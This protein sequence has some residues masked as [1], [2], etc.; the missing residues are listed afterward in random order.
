MYILHHTIS[1]TPS[2]SKQR[3]ANKVNIQKAPHVQAA[4]SRNKS[5]GPTDATLGRPSVC[6]TRSMPSARV[7]SP[8]PPQSPP[9]LR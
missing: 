6:H 8:H 2:R 3:K 7:P 5:S 4:H 9:L 1:L